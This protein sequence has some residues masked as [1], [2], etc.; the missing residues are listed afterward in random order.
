MPRSTNQST[1]T[2]DRDVSYLQSRTD[3]DA[4]NRLFLSWAKTFK[5]SSTR[6][7]LQSKM[8]ISNI[9]M[10]QEA[11][12]LDE[13][14][15]NHAPSSHSSVPFYDASATTSRASPATP[16]NISMTPHYD[17]FPPQRPQAIPLESTEQNFTPGNGGL[18]SCFDTL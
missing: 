4:V 7:L 1:S 6:R 3:V 12:E 10:Q 8:K 17:T 13:V 14:M 5:T 18:Q 9:I 16:E 15:M 11:E 2:F